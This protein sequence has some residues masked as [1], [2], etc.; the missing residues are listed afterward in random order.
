MFAYLAGL[1]EASWR[2]KM[3]AFYA[4]AHA[5]HAE[6]HGDCA[7]C[8]LEACM[9]P[10]T[11][12]PFNFEKETSDGKHGNS[13]D[14]PLVFGLTRPVQ[15]TFQGGFMARKVEKEAVEKEDTEDFV[16]PAKTPPPAPQVSP[17]VADLRARVAAHAAGLEAKAKAQ[18]EAEG[19]PVTEAEV[20]PIYNTILNAI[21]DAAT[22][23]L[24]T[25]T[26]TLGQPFRKS[27]LDEIVSRLR[28][29]G[30]GAEVK[31]ILLLVSW[32]E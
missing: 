7:E 20:G 31:G 26:V 30:L 11:R 13:Y 2:A 5:T 6:R 16:L 17:F 4:D 10:L 28:A 32:G 25:T 27:L 15:S 14:Q 8:E 22:N 12:P 1:G 19:R 24:T 3:K 21:T 23:G 29:L 9:P 18:E